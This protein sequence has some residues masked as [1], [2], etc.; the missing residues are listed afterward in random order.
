MLQYSTATSSVTSS[1]AYVQT[2]GTLKG[3]MRNTFGP[4]IVMNSNLQQLQITS[5]DYSTFTSTAETPVELLGAHEFY[6]WG[7]GN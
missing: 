1:N 7:W 3:K 4:L 2:T 6:F 5:P